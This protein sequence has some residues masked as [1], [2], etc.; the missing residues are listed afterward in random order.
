VVYSINA[1][2]KIFTTRLCLSEASCGKA[3]RV[4]QAN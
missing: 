3:T 2:L 1:I 4:S